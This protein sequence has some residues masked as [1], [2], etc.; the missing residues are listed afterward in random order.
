MTSDA[1]RQLHAPGSML[2]LPNAWDHASGAALAAEGFPAI[3]TTSLGVAAANGLPDG[4]G[5]ARAETVALTR[6]LVRLP[7]LVSVDVEAGFSADPNEVAALT[8]ELAAIGAVGINLEDG[9]ADG[10]LADPG[11]QADLIAAAKSGAPDLFLNARI[12][13]FWHNQAGSETLS[14]AARYLEAGADGIFVPGLTDEHL[15]REL[16]STMAAPL[17]LLYQPHW[18][19]VDRLAELGVR[20]VSTGSLLFRAALGTAITTARAIRANRPIPTTP[21]TYAEVQQLP[22]PVHAE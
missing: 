5:A 4:Q 9:R 16:V 7:V 6:L 14:R 8:A 18:H 1:F 10:T 15:V 19:P 21:L 20:R 3:G 17:N 12:D 13:A 11:R 2:L 22:D